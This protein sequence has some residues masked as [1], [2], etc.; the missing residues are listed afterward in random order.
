MPPRADAAVAPGP[1]GRGAFVALAAIILAFI[2]FQTTW[3]RLPQ[4]SDEVCFKAAGREWAASGHFAAPELI[5]ISRLKMGVEKIFFLYVPLYTFLFGLVVKAIGIG[6]R[7][8]M[9]YDAVITGVL[10]GLTFLL[11]DRVTERKARW[12]AVVAAAAMIPL[13]TA[14]RPDALATCFGIVSVLLIG[15]LPSLRRLILSGVALELCAGTSPPAAMIFCVIG[16]NSFVWQDC[17][18]VCPAVASDALGVSCAGAVCARLG[19]DPGAEPVER[20]AVLRQRPRDCRHRGPSAAPGPNRPGPA[21][22][23]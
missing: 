19:T 18:L 13:T 16:L 14:G 2:A 7:A 21:G 1:S 20:T 9:F 10:A 22:H 3:G 6:W 5:N 12:V 23:W 15:G 8:C 11:T 4:S 17:A